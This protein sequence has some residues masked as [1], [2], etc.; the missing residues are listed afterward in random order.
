[1][2]EMP[3]SAPTVLAQKS[4]TLRD[5]LA[6]VVGPAATG[7]VDAQPRIALP[8]DTL[9]LGRSWTDLEYARLHDSVLPKQPGCETPTHAACLRRHAPNPKTARS[10]WLTG[11]LPPFQRF[12]K[13]VSFNAHPPNINQALEYA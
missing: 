2:D 1:M 3:Q 4:H 8:V 6:R 13:L 9:V 5:L 12:R 7:A 11:L 10:L